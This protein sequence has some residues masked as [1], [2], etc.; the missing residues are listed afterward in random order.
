M[1]GISHS[2]ALLP[3]SSTF[4]YIVSTVCGHLQLLINKALAMHTKLLF[5][6]IHCDNRQLM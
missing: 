5:Y 6:C 1:T 4:Y 3:R 2:E